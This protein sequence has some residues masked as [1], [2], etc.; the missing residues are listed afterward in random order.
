[1]FVFALNDAASFRALDAFFSTYE[2][3][4]GSRRPKPPIVLV[5]NK[6]DIVSP[7]A[8][9]RSSASASSSSSSSSSSAASASAS[10][11]APAATRQVAEAEARK[12]AERFGAIYLEC[13]ALTGEGVHE[14]F[15]HVVRAAR[16]RALR[17]DSESDVSDGGG[18]ASG[19]GSGRRRK[20]RGWCFLL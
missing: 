8:G 15:E 7:H 16:R 5:G 11:S 12:V 13:S 18:R 9:G 1:M 20:K 4:N 6:L 17:T 10:S 19:A 2:Q 14:V 3:I